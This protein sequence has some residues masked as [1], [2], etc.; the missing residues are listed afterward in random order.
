[1][2]LFMTLLAAFQTL[3]Y[4][5]SGQDD[6]LVGSP[7]AHRDRREIEGL[8]GFFVN[9]LILRLDFSGAPSF[10]ELLGRAREV[11]LDAHHHQDLPFE[12]VV[13]ALNPQR[14]LS[15]HP[16]FQAL[17]VLQNT[18][19]QAVAP[20]ELNV[21][22]VEVATNT[23]QFELSLYLRERDDKLLGYFEYASDLFDQA[24]VVRM[25]GHFEILLQG[26]VAHPEQSVATLPLM[27]EAEQ[28]WLRLEWNAT[29][30][31][32]PA[33]RCIHELFEAQVE[34]TP[35]AIAVEFNG[36]ELTY[37]ELNR[38]AN[39]VAH[40][41]LA[42]GVGPEQPV[43]ICVG[44]SLEMVIGLLGILKAG[45]AY[46]P[47][48]PGYPDARLKFMLADSQATVLVTTETMVK[49][50]RWLLEE[51]DPRSSSLNPRLK[52]ALLNRNRTTIKKENAENVE[53]NV[54]SQS[55][56]YVIYT[57]GSTGTPKG[58]VGLHRGAVN[59][60]AW[61]W[62]RYPFG[63][64]EVCCSKTALSFVDSV[65]EIFGP[66]LQG[67]RLVIAPDPIAQEPHRLI[68]FLAD[69]GITRIVLVPSLLKALLDDS[70]DLGKKLPKLRYWTSSGEELSAALADRFKKSHP[71]AVL[72]NLYGS[73]EVG[74]DVTCF[75]CQHE[76][77]AASVPIGR[78]I[79]NT[80]IYLLDANLQLVPMGVRG[81]LFVGG[82]ALARGYWRR[83][84]LTVA[85]FVTNPFSADVSSRLFRS[86]DSARY[87]PDGNLEY[88]GRADQQVKI[89]GQRVELGEID[90]VLRQ[91]PEVK[92]CAV[93][94]RS[95][96]PTD[97][98]DS[99]K[100]QTPDTNSITSL[101]AYF[102]PKRFPAA[103]S[104]DLREF[105]RKRL[106]DIMIPAAFLMLD[107][108]PLLP[109]GKV[110]RLTL[111]QRDELAP[112]IETKDLAPRTE[113]E[114]L[115]AQVWQDALKL[116][117]I[118]VSTNFF[119]LGGHSLLAA[120]IV[121]K[122]RTLFKRP[123]SLRDI[124]EAPTVE[125]L[126]ARIGE[127][128]RGDGEI[129]LPSILPRPASHRAPLTP[130]QQ[131][132]FLFSQ[133]FGGGDFLNMPY[134]YRLSGTLDPAIMELA[135][136]EIIN[137]HEIL[138][139]SF[140]ELEGRAVQR[141]GRRRKFVLQTVDLSRLTSAEASA[142]LVRISRADAARVFD[143][144]KAPLLR[145]QLIRMAEQEHVLLVT[146]HHIITDQWSMGVFRREL[147]E[148][149]GAFAYGMPATL[150]ALTL[151]FG[152]FASWQQDLL[153]QGV[154][155]AQIA[156]WRKQLA[157]PL[158]R[159]DFQR[160]K[161]RKKGVRF[162]SARRP[163][164]IADGLFAAVKAFARRRGC[165]PFM[166]FITAL[167]ILLHKM[168]GQS[169]IRIATLVADRN[170]PGTEGLIGY[171]VNAL[172]L[173]TQVTARLGAQELLERVRSVCLD[174]YAHQEVPFEHLEA[175]LNRG[176]RSPRAPLFQVMFNYRN[177]VSAPLDA[178]GLTI[179]SWYGDLR[180]ANPGIDISRLDLNFHLREVSTKL[181]GAVN[182][183]IDLFD[184]ARIAALLDGFCRVL[185]QLVE[186]PDRRVAEIS[187]R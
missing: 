71:K 102:V 114:A 175:R 79:A 64:S 138:R 118:D 150:P 127:A 76:T 50:R 77:P 82:D 20:A 60:F 18:P 103:N 146:L 96:N 174:A 24:T 183:R 57:S 163:I 72:L 73:S 94:A 130:S 129:D 92:D 99:S 116:E 187:L 54:T 21:E 123:V 1:V 136:G 178:G 132:L 115:V 78:P 45:G 13:E 16:L 169:D 182:F 55:P 42:L 161:K 91:H 84:E 124:F 95:E 86:G 88:L 117:G 100:A 152:D 87:L 83:P 134:A 81:E 122:L 137:R 37:G 62:R 33:D 157:E 68:G 12:K 121:V 7:V 142:R 19:R 170:R 89:R 128:L 113:I 172:V 131:Q 147:A 69:H 14:E 120:Q 85:K 40:H 166:V 31:D 26:I 61:M 162:Q 110:D 185:R 98:I 167:D 145:A 17:F 143:L 65:W 34:R 47:L 156:Y 23:S 27:S 97:L 93:I 3:L 180:A 66:L 56:A 35:N 32:F 59:R 105:V 126:S 160:R 80:Q 101:I 53:C 46:V 177:Q 109:N 70:F 171:F 151:Q 184:E 63:A 8:V 39:G 58:V 9:T 30:A 44:R 176:P 164:E 165:T 140:V 153:K 111:R 5:Y 49:G 144:E 148:I 75:E 10:T 11:C 48:D 52:L 74:A 133:L 181:T 154:F 38:R 158:S 149:Y 173:R 41:L 43:G 125:R 4:R 107:E 155:N 108:L 28:R 25:A 179:A 139:T 135:V 29:A 106:P 112:P 2:T 159:L 168:T 104:N 6:I 141:I 90:A 67:T 51:R 36:V 15:R 186:C 22:P 119:T